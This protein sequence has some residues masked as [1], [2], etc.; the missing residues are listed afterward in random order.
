ME[1]SKSEMLDVP[2]SKIK[3]P[4]ANPANPKSE[5]GNQKPGERRDTTHNRQQEE[6]RTEEPH[7]TSTQHP[8]PHSHTG[9]ENTIIHRRG[10][11]GM[12][13]LQSYCCSRILF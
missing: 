13:I 5:I 8:A 1:R 7:P 12:F 11:R 3:N 10:G 9:T 2:V 4:G 6:Q